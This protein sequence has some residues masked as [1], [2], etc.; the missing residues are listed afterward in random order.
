MWIEA[1]VI[2]KARSSQPEQEP[3]GA[4]VP[5][6]LRGLERNDAEAKG[7]GKSYGDHFRQRW[8]R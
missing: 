1:G 7:N 8:S 5:L 2:A 3:R 6:G 4:Y